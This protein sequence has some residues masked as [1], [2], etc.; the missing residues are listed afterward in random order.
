MA[1][2]PHM[3]GGTSYQPLKDF[4]MI[5]GGVTFGNVLVVRTDSPIKTLADFIA[6]A[7]DGHLELWGGLQIP[8]WAVNTIAAVSKIKKEKTCIVTNW[9]ASIFS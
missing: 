2:N 6:A 9:P 8:D 1:V 3:P 7:K 4:E 5:S